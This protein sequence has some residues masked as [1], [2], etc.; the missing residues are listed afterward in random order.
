MENM[1][2]EARRWSHNTEQELKNQVLKTKQLEKQLKKAK[3]SEQKKQEDLI[4]LQVELNGKED[5]LNKCMNELNQLKENPANRE[6]PVCF[7]KI[8]SHD[9]LLTCGHF[10]CYDCLHNMA[11]IESF[12]DRLRCPVCQRSSKFFRFY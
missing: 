1:Y 11:D 2:V 5:Q 4:N 6:C 7:E 9:Y 12:Q 10:L 8:Q 3:K